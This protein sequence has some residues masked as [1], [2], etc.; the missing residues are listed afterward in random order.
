MP[1]TMRRWDG[2]WNWDQ[3]YIGL[4][5]LFGLFSDE[6]YESAMGFRKG[7]MNSWASKLSTLSMRADWVMDELLGIWSVMLHWAKQS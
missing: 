5:G 2:H 1:P 6:I 3:V 4:V 7:R